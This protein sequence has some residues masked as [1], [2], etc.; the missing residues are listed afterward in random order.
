MDLK[1]FNSTVGTIFD[2]QLAEYGFKLKRK[3]TEKLFCARIYTTSDRYLKITASIHPRDF[4]PH[5]NI[6]LGQGSFEWPECDWNS[7]A[8]WRIK[9]SIDPKTSPKE[10]SL[11]QMDLEK[12]EHSLAH[13]KNELL[14][15]GHQFLVGETEFFTSV[16]SAQNRDREPYKIHSP[17]ANGGLETIIDKESKALKE[18]FS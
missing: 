18:K 9:N 10:Y 8:L 3:K 5:Y 15:Y 17:T 12:L 4:P 2:K 13:A 6:V 11:E 16:R 7:V 1:T 14:N